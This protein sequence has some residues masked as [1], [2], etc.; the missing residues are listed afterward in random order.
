MKDEDYSEDDDGM[1]E[2]IG[3]SGQ[4]EEQ[5]DADN[6][7][8]DAVEP[9]PAAS[10]AS[11][12]SS[13]AAA[14]AAAASSLKMNVNENDDD[15][16]DEDGSRA[17]AI[18]LD[19]DILREFKRADRKAAKRLITTPKG[20][21]PE[22]ALRQSLD[23]DKKAIDVMDVLN[24]IPQRTPTTFAT[25]PITT[26]SGFMFQTLAAAAASRMDHTAIIKS[27]VDDFLT[28]ESNGSM[29]GGGGG[30]GSASTS[31]SAGGSISSLIAA[32]KPA[33]VT[34]SAAAPASVLSKSMIQKFANTPVTASV[35]LF[36]FL[37]RASTAV[38][39]LRANLQRSAVAAMSTAVSQRRAK[40]SDSKLVSPSAAASASASAAATAASNDP[41]LTID[42]IHNTANDYFMHVEAN[43]DADLEEFQLVEHGMRRSPLKGKHTMFINAPACYNHYQHLKNPRAEDC[44]GMTQ[45]LQGFDDIH[46]E[47]VT[48]KE[49]QSM[50]GGVA[51]AA[52]MPR[53]Q[54]L[55]FLETGKLPSEWLKSHSTASTVAS[56]SSATAAKPAASAASTPT[57]NGLEHINRDAV[58]PCV[59]CIRAL[60][61]CV[62][63]Q[64]EPSN[65][66]LNRKFLLQ[67]FYNVIDGPGGYNRE[68]C[69][70]PASKG[71]FNGLAAPV[72]MY[73]HDLLR[74]YKDPFDDKWHISQ[75]AMRWPPVGAIRGEAPAA[76]P[77][78]VPFTDRKYA[79]K[80]LEV[81]RR[82]MKSFV[83]EQINSLAD[84]MKSASISV[85]STPKRTTSVASASAAAAAAA[86]SSSSAAAA[87]AAAA[88][89]AA[90]PSPPIF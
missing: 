88:T 5:E 14:A 32:H 67:R 25:G 16:D 21:T 36:D 34:S 90:T 19:D 68:H 69:L 54:F 45:R 62:I 60:T 80:T 85:S 66:N 12:S 64:L 70:L 6:G 77:A 86:S 89:A 42:D 79:E 15:E 59:L 51:L 33:P 10:A 8:M 31:A 76:T 7:M 27:A 37:A 35:T 49:R 48:D 43:I 47:R 4:T 3:S 81:S 9:K 53:N 84:A 38:P 22:S 71:R 28:A 50:T 41:P 17:A 57:A 82:V 72:A 26:G 2:G 63:C 23:T 20:M 65:I 61:Q 74:A 1:T 46:N 52:Y 18:S 87:S 13:S 73:R 83:D 40:Q 11:A 78:P 24:K 30:A 44:I 58:N 29:S 56:S 75:R 39:Y 55:E